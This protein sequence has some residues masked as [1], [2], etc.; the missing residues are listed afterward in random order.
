MTDGGVEG[1][2]DGGGDG[3]GDGGE[4]G[5]VVAAVMVAAV[6]VVTNGGGD[7]ADAADRLRVEVLCHIPVEIPI[8]GPDS[9][10]YSD[11]MGEPTFFAL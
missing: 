8:V 5:D 6:A 9:P 11:K 4:G 2:D 1:G 10:F 7:C 3:H